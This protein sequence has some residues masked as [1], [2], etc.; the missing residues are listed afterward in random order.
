[1]KPYSHPD[2]LFPVPE[3]ILKEEQSKW[4]LWDVFRR[5]WVV[6]G[7]EEWVR[8]QCAHYLVG[9][10]GYPRTRLLIE[11]RV[12]SGRSARRFDLAVAGVAGGMKMLMECKAPSVP[13]DEEVWWQTVCYNHTVEAE[14]L[15]L[16]NGVNLK[17]WRRR[18]GLWEARGDLPSWPEL[19]G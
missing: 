16:T 2:L 7:P 19:A 8:Q 17:V 1:M 5:K 15:V 13:L 3:L 12:G 11:K 4:V 9:T 18:N 10:L 14:W 6:S